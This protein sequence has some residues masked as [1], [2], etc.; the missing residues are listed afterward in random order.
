[1]TS[2][3]ARQ[4]KLISLPIHVIVVA[5][6]L[7][8][9]GD[10]ASIAS[11]RVRALALLFS[12]VMNYWPFLVII[13][14][15]AIGQLFRA[16]I[17]VLAWVIA[18]I[19]AAGLMST[20]SLIVNHYTQAVPLKRWLTPEEDVTLKARFPHPYTQYASTSQGN[21]LLIRKSDYDVSLVEFLKSINNFRDR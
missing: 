19:V 3:R 2:Q 15:I 8:L 5:V 14:Y 16:R 1:M 6:L 18:Y 12:S 4:P 7:F 17:G 21:R 10:F 13:A 11:L 9:G 20:P